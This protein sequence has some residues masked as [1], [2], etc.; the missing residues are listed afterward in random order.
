MCGIAGVFGSCDGVDAAIVGALTDAVAHRGPDDSG[1]WVSPDGDAVLG[2]RRLAIIDLSEQG[3]Q[4]MVSASG[5]FVVVYNGEIYNFE[6]L[7]RELSVRG[8][9]FRGTSDT[10]VMLAA[11]DEWGVE[12]TVPKLNGMF[13]VSVVDRVERRLYAFRDRLGLK[14]LYYVWRG[15]RLY[16]SSELT[17]EFA[18]LS[19]REIS[20]RALALYFRNNF[21][22]APLTVYA[23]VF[24]LMPGH[25]ACCDVE[26]AG[27][28]RFKTDRAYWSVAQRAD[29]L[30]ATRDESMSMDEAVERVE[31]TLDRSVRR[32]MIADVPLGAFLSGGID[33]SLVVA[34]MQRASATA[35]RTFTIGFDDLE[36]NEADCARR[37]AAYLRTDHTELRVTERDALDVIPQL[38]GMYGEPFADSSQIPTHLV[39]KLTRKSVTVALSGDG[40]DELFAGYSSYR[41]LAAVQSVLGAAPPGA[42]VAA[43]ALWRS[44]LASRA[45]FA[46]A[47][48]QRYE[49][50]FNAV[51]LF[52]RGAERRIPPGLHASYSIPER[53]VL[54]ARAGDSVRPFHRCAG[55][56][57]EQKMCDDL[58]VYL[59]DDILTKVDRASMAVSLEVRAPF[60]DDLDL[61]DVAW[62]VPF[63]H[64]NDGT[65]GKR[66]LKAALARHV[67]REL[68]D[69]PKMGFAIPLGR[70]LNGPLRDWVLA[71]SD[72]ARIRRDGYLDP[73]TTA[74]LVAHERREEEWYAYKLWAVCIFQSWLTDFHD[75]PAPN[76]LRRRPEPISAAL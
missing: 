23:D 39:S 11:F 44:S 52:A 49:W 55:N 22:P 72:P 68:F 3:R 66:V 21:I 65:A 51:R 50:A 63:R 16:F 5:R 13:A 6:A 71:T 54:G 9:R 15:G 62:S 67:P 27:A 75:A 58:L 40:G 60:T 41:R 14:P 31:A 46:A 48:E 61:F 76:L 35:V 17:R 56:V 26:S 8:H 45:L 43:A 2:H 42:Y 19:G 70:W 1:V 33:S 36:R 37:I 28:H 64:K 34:H 7:R 38:A 73:A 29:E 10:E 69:R 12:Q 25:L 47:G 32:R 53:I 57:T 18:T 4:P 74:A 59:P 24:K 30:M 20:R